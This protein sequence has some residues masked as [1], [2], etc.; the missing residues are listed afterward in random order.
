MAQTHPQYDPERAPK[1]DSAGP[2]DVFIQPKIAGYRQLSQH[3]AT[4]MNQLKQLEAQCL[5]A[6]DTLQRAEF[7]QTS[8]QVPDP[9]WLSIARTSIETGFMAAVRSIAKP[10]R[11]NLPEG[12]A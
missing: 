11:V 4:L 6:L 12:Q 9:R 7:A 1:A 3:E 10:Q 8:D 5:G 2:G